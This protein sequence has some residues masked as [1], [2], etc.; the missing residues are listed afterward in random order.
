MISNDYAY[1]KKYTDQLKTSYSLKTIYKTTIEYFIETSSTPPDKRAF[2]KQSFTVNNNTYKTYGI[3][4]D[5][6]IYAYIYK[7]NE[8]YMSFDIYKE[9]KKIIYEKYN[10][11]R[12]LTSN[13]TFN[14]TEN[15][16]SIYKN[17]L[18]K[19]INKIKSS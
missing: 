3:K 13:E 2:D 12:K 14:Q 19:I 4:E 5:N 1:N 7:N 6:Y 8:E 17:K 10:Q 16:K 11:K 9:N 18:N 15:L